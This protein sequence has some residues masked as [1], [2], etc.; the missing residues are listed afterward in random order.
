MH[1]EEHQRQSKR[2]T[3]TFEPGDRVTIY[4][5]AVSHRPFIEGT[6]TVL[7]ALPH[8]DDLYRVRFDGERREVDRLVHAGSWQ[9]SPDAQLRV[10]LAY[11]RYDLC[12]EILE[13][14]PPARF[15]NTPKRSTLGKERQPITR[16]SAF[17][18]RN[19]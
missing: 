10:L 17:S 16:N 11:W 18:V 7:A 6:A 13:L 19:G 2:G 1:D 9:T 4:R 3:R 15:W 12:P 8:G 14:A 5:V